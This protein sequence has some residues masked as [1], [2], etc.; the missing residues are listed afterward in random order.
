MTLLRLRVRGAASLAVLLLGGSQIGI[1]Q[2][3][4]PASA[5]MLDPPPTRRDDVKETL[6]GVELIDPYRWLENQD[7]AETRAFIEAQNAY[8]HGLLDPLPY[9]GAI[10]ERLTTLSRQDSQWAPTEKRRTLLH[11][12]PP[13]ER[14][15][16]DPLRSRR[17]ER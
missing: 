9:L 13:C 3:P 16:A 5:R 14:R 6:H 11:P 4:G 2:A 7:A 10:R 8:A 1:G 15:P 12:S 17:F